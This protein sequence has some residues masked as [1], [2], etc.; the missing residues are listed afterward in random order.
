VRLRVGGQPNGGVAG[1]YQYKFNENGA[2]TGWKSDPLNPRKTRDYGNSY[3]FVRNPAIHYLLPNS[4]SGVVKESRPVI[5]AHIFPSTT[6][7]VDTASL[8]LE[9]DGVEYKHV[10]AGYD[11]V[12]KKFTFIPPAPLVDGA[13]QAALWL[14]S[15]INSVNCD[16]ARFTV[17]AVPVEVTESEELLPRQFALHQNFPNPFNPETKIRF[18]L[19]RPTEVRVHIFNL[20]G[21]EVVIL[22]QEKMPAGTHT[23]S[24]D[25]RNKAGQVAPSGIYFLRVQAGEKVAVKKL[26]VVR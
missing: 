10:G 17:Q 6:S 2:S 12:T 11:P 9:L 26:M 8:V 20:L 1:A 25:G 14:A 15:S 7:F 4:I 16:T 21:E 23:L 19:P 22:K 18:N 13:H 3:L 5:S 24:W